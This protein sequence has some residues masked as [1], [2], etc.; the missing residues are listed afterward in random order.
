MTTRPGYTPSWKT[1]EPLT[2]QKPNVSLTLCISRICHSTTQ[3]MIS[4]IRPIALAMSQQQQRQQQQQHQQHSKTASHHSA[5]QITDEMTA[6]YCGH[7]TQLSM[8]MSM[9]L[10]GQQ[11]NRCHSLETDLKLIAHPT[12]R[13][14]GN[15]DRDKTWPMGQHQTLHTNVR[16][17]AERAWFRMA[18]YMIDMEQ[19][20]GSMVR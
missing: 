13:H 4:G 1:T 7:I 19:H 15:A 17:Y 5:G 12:V 6:E 9:S 20:L 16:T 14:N 8:S 3:E 2:S 10:V 18:N 11:T